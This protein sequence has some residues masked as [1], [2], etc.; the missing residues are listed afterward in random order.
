METPHLDK[1]IEWL[2]WAKKG[3]NWN[4]EREKQLAEYKAI[5]QVLRIHDVVGRSEQLVCDNHKPDLEH[6]M[7]YSES[8][9]KNCKQ[10]V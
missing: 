1:E 9:C 5:K 8:I 10:K 2:E 6:F 4:S 7:K 3:T